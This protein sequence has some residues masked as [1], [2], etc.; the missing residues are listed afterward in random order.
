MEL[1]DK[2]S[3]SPYTKKVLSIGSLWHRTDSMR[4]SQRHQCF[5]DTIRLFITIF[6]LQKADMTSIEAPLSEKKFQLEG[7][8]HF[9]ISGLLTVS[10][11]AASDSKR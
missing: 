11:H 6:E 8:S 2:N 5:V 1:S 7:R 9:L 3:L 4:Q 10:S